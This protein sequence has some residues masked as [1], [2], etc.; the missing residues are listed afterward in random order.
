MTTQSHN[1]LTELQRIPWIDVAFLMGSDGSVLSHVGENAA[2]D[3]TGGFGAAT[4]EPTE[5][6]SASLYMTAITSEIYLG[7]LFNAEIPIDDVRL[8]VR[9]QESPLATVIG[10]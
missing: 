9:A 6:V 3:P 10:I 2:F 4:S 1:I 5:D 8:R 7:V